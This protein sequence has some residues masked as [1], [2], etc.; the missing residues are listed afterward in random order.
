MKKQLID[1]FDIARLGTIPHGNAVNAIGKLGDR[2]RTAPDRRPGR[3]PRGRHRGH[4][5]RRRRGEQRP[6]REP[7]RPLPLPVPPLR[8]QPVPRAVQPGQRQRAV[9]G[10]ASGQRRQDDDPRLQ[11]R[12]G[13]GRHRQHPLHRAPGRR[14]ADALDVLADGA[15]RAGTGRPG[16]PHL[17]LAY[18]QF[19]NLEF[20][21][22][23]DGKPG[24]IRWP[25]I[26]INMMEKVSGPPDNPAID[27]S[28]Y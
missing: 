28:E 17:V 27:P 20:F 5:R 18:S 25:H 2:R 8:R 15:R 24:L 16:G 10:R 6:E 4:R 21:P 12:G 3:L 11:H 9:A 26:S 22:R 19:I 14:V 1:G 7:A 23:F 13:R